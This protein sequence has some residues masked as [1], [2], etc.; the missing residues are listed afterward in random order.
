[1]RDSNDL[2]QDRRTVSALAHALLLAIT[3]RR[4]CRSASGIGC[5]VPALSELR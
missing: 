4:A 5:A 3:C 2:S 1:L